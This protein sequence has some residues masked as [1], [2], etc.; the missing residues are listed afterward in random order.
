MAK[1]SKKALKKRSQVEKMDWSGIAALWMK[2][3]RSDTGDWYAG[4]A[5]EHLVVRAFALSGLDVE[6]PYDVPPGGQPLEQIDGIVYLD[7][8]AFLIECK[9]Q[10]KV[11]IEAIAKLRNQLLRRPDTA[12]GCVFVSREFTAPALMLADFAVPHR[13]LLWTGVDI[14]NAIAG[15][16]FASALREKYRHLCKYGLTDHSPNYRALEV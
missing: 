5:L 4:K 15:K 8:L 9:D 12:L 2:I 10:D 16:D 13:I 14:E 1:P 6:Y 11:D 7:G 3:K